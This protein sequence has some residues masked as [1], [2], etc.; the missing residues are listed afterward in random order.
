MPLHGILQLTST[1]AHGTWETLNQRFMNWSKRL[2]VGRHLN[3]TP[4]AGR[5][6]R[7]L[8]LLLTPVEPHPISQRIWRLK[9]KLNHSLYS[10]CSLW[11][12]M[13]LMLNRLT[14]NGSVRPAVGAAH[15]PCLLYSW[16]GNG[17]RSGVCLAVD[18]CYAVAM[19]M[20]FREAKQW[21]PPLVSAAYCNIQAIS[22]SS[23]SLD[24]L[25]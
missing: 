7:H 5:S 10:W 20:A 6:P 2:R 14:R 9:K 23:V 25:V 15:P 17:G 16:K 1:T 8:L 24:M 21:E 22:F 19:D 13:C 11:N 12:L 18:R 4:L 3:Q